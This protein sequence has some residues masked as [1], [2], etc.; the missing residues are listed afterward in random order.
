M[1]ANNTNNNFAVQL[2]EIARLKSAGEMSA[3]AFEEDPGCSYMF[4]DFEGKAKLDILAWFWER[5]LWLSVA[6]N[7]ENY[8]IMNGEDVIAETCILFHD[9]HVVTFW[10]KM[11]AGILK[12]PFVAGMNAVNRMLKNGNLSLEDDILWGKL[13]LDK[14]KFSKI[15]HVA[16]DP[17]FQGRGLGRK[18]VEH[19]IE[20]IRQKGYSGCFLGT[21][22]KANVD[23]YTKLGFE[24]VGEQ[25]VDETAED[26]PYKYLMLMKF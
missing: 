18:I 2:F 1:S 26:S 15:E 12:M 11:R 8:V 13:G 23:F 3:R 14:T 22:K 25:L 17:K 6:F 16:V 19:S 21:Q 10:D 24:K 20:R 9:G 5:Y 7:P 4:V